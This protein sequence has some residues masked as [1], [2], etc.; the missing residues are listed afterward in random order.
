M[1]TSSGNSSWTNPISYLLGE[2][3]IKANNLIAN[4][5]LSYQILKGLEIK[6]TFG[7]TNL[8]S[9][10]VSTTPL[11]SKTPETRANS[12]R[13]A[14]FANNNI[15]TWIIE[16]QI[17]YQLTINNGKLDALVGTTFQQ[18]NSDGSRF[19]A[20][21]FNSDE[22]L[23]DIRSASSISVLSNIDFV[24]KYTAL[25]ARLNYVW[26]D[27]YVVNL[28]GRR[29]GSSR[30]GANNQFHNFGSAGGAWVFSQE[31][32]I[33]NNL[34]FLSFGKLKLSYGTTGSDQI[35]EYQYLNLY[36]PITG[37]VGVPYQKITALGP[38][39]LSNPYLQWEETK[40]LQTGIDLSFFSDRLSLGASYFSNKSANQLLGYSLSVVTGFNSIIENFPAIIQNKG[41]EFTLNSFNFRGAGFSWN[42]VFN[43]TVP[44]NKLLSF[45]NLDQSSY[46]GSLVVGQ[47]INIIKAFHYLGVDPTT[48]MY[49]IESKNDP[50]NPVDPDDK[51]VII[52]TSPKFYGGFQNTFKYKNF[53]A[54]VFFQ[55]VKQIGSNYFYG[56]FPGNIGT[57]QPIWVLDRWR[58]AG[59]K[60][61]QE[62]LSANYNNTIMPYFNTSFYSDALYTDASYIRLKN[63]SVSWQLPK[64]FLDRAHLNALRLYTQAQN[65]LTITRYKGLDPETLNVSSLPPLKVWTFGIQ[66]GL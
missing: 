44:E 58:K 51:T 3:V 49:L 5:N 27:K 23:K 38:K 8:S 6:S 10:E 9:N 29:D 33:K 19:N 2:Y 66:L 28:N 20:S 45:P 56:N 42:T 34:S 63:V 54:D 35:G 17:N 62:V 48:G 15:H 22:V 13:R 65:I 24:Y 46:S 14:S 61:S 1:Q 47:N 11:I 18:N 60:A 4:A 52:N 39:G 53:E 32:F 16:P 57:N 36:N 31:N 21:G 64:R 55:F 41:W 26:K 30:F 50:Y 40:K 43:L 25:F 59:D 37:N 7:Y 12:L